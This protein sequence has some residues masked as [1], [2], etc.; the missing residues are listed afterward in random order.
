LAGLSQDYCRT[1]EGLLSQIIFCPPC[2]VLVESTPS[3]TSTSSPSGLHQDNQ[4]SF[5]T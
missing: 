4:D 3:P 5:P 1:R 2:P